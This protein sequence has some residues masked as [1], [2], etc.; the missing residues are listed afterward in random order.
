[1]SDATTPAS[2]VEAF[3]DNIRLYND[4]REAWEAALP[5]DAVLETDSAWPD[6]G[7]FEGKAEI[8]AFLR[9]FEEAWSEIRYDVEQ[10]EQVGD[11]VVARSR[12]VV[13][14]SSSAV[15]TEV[16]FSAVASVDE[17]GEVRA[18]RFF[19]DHDRALGFA[20]T[21]AR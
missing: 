17:R 16:G 21:R 7:R 19:F 15:P 3:L 10:V 2:K 9:K 12:W 1:M 14:G 5:E 8:L 18:S 4:D 13:R 11:A 20:R 6:G